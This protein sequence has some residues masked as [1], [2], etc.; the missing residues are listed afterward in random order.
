MKLDPSIM[1][2]LS[3]DDFRVMVAIEMGMRNHELVPVQLIAT[4]AALRHGGVHKSLTLLLRHKMLHHDR[5]KY[6]GYRLTN[7]GYDILALKAMVNRGTISGIGRQ[8][9]V[10]KESDIFAVVNDEGEEMALK[11]H[12]LG[13]TSFRAVKEKRDYVQHRKTASWLYLSRLA[14]VKEYAFMKALHENGFPVPTPVDQCRHCVV[15]SLCDG[16]LLLQQ[17][18]IDEYERVYDELMALVLRLGRCGLIHGDF[19]EF[20]VMIDN[21]EQTTLIDFPQMVS[22]SHANAKFYFDRDVF[23]IAEFFRKRF[24]FESTNP[25]PQFEDIMDITHKEQDLDVEVEASGFSKEAHAAF[26]MLVRQREDDADGAGEAA[27]AEGA[28][29][30]EEKEGGAAGAGSVLAGAAQQLTVGAGEGGEGG[31]GGDDVGDDDDDELDWLVTPAGGDDAAGGDAVAAS[32]GGTGETT[33]AASSGGGENEEV[34]EVAEVVRSSGGRKG[35]RTCDTCGKIGHLRRRCPEG[36]GGAAGGDA[37][38]EDEEDAGPG[39]TIEE[40]RRTARIR[41]QVKRKIDR[42]RDRNRK[43]TRNNLK[44]KDRKANARVIAFHQ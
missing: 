34:A 6:D 40:K 3:K 9:G 43:A 11:L 35:D 19:N 1:R 13:R 23:G 38:D 29:G 26:E 32:V 5:T 18:K 4:I 24:L 37:E 44:S 15:M 7:A 17:H 42:K 20:N 21:D 8:I 36:A 30:G 16:L 31:E 41:D 10:G 14:A 2:Y 22:T 12:R 25:I 33:A 28:G 27:G 39:Q